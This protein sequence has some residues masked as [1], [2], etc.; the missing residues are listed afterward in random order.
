ML[1]DPKDLQRYLTAV[2]NLLVDVSE[3]L[4]AKSN[5]SDEHKPLYRQIVSPLRGRKAAGASM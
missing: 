4:A 1:P 3:K 5:L 2:R